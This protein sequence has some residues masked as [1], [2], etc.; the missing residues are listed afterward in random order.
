M[1]RK[2]K[3]V[4]L[5]MISLIIAVISTCNFSVALKARKYTCYE[6]TVKPDVCVG[7]VIINGNLIPLERYQNDKIKIDN[8]KSCLYSE[9]VQKFK[10]ITS[11]ID[12]VII[13]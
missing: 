5:I 11:S 10:I 12:D 1:N 8:K 9:D 6:V 13:I 3:I 7:R 2:L 4:F